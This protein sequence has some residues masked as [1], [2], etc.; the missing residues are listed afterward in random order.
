MKKFY[1]IV[2]ILAIATVGLSSK[3]QDNKDAK[4]QKKSVSKAKTTKTGKEK[5]NQQKMMK[6]LYTNCKT[7]HTYEYPT[8]SDPALVNCPR[9]KMI[10]VF[11]RPEE[12]PIIVKMNDIYGKYGPV[13][14]SHRI[15][16]E[17]SEMSGGCNG[18]HHYN[19]TGPVLKCK[20]C[21]AEE[22]KREDLSKPDLNAAYHRQCINCHRQ[23]NRN[24]N[25]DGCHKL[26]ENDSEQKIAILVNAV[27]NAQHPEIPHP[28]KVV[29]ET[30]YNKGK[31]VTFF[32][33]EHNKIFGIQ[34]IECHRDENCIRCHDINRLKKG[35][36]ISFQQKKIHKT[37]DEHHK[38]CVACHQKQS[39]DKCHKSNI[40]DRFNHT[41]TAGWALKHYH[42][43]ISCNKCHGGKIGK[44]N[45]NC[46][47]CHKKWELG[48]FNHSVTGII[49]NENHKEID[50]ES[51]HE[52]KNYSVKPVCNSCHDDKNYPKDKPGRIKSIR[53]VSRK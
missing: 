45:R 24:V 27:S 33:D 48:N 36:N 1:L 13:I 34:C 30:K 15:H 17:M 51:C 52:N 7:C 12:G 31:F 28:E 49:L 47:S 23:W 5:S 35:N 38:P 44:V 6:K 21:H 16:S 43:T 25:C 42:Q 18:C 29:Y 22:R 3:W 46:S 53:V 10:S 40:M 39:C 14:F 41:I 26:K 19:T 8:K 4:P 2:I 50:C 37:I 32:H 9:S 11:H 20:K